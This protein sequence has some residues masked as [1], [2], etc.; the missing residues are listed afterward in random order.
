MKTLINAVMNPGSE[1][2][3]LENKS[4]NNELITKKNSW[5]KATNM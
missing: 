4:S 2:K 1:S 5:A 3:T